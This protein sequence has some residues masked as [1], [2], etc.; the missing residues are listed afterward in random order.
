MTR[1]GSGARWLAVAGVVLVGLSLPGCGDGGASAGSS[2]DAA[3][4][5]NSF[6]PAFPIDRMPSPGQ[7][8]SGSLI[9]GVPAPVAIAGQ[10][11]SF[12]PQVDASDGAAVSFSILLLF[13]A[14]PLGD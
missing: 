9:Q 8:G 10:P 7:N 14:V 6:G 12:Q 2:V 1:V 4:A 11:Y 3:N 5:A 13:I